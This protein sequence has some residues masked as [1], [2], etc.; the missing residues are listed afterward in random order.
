MDAKI[1]ETLQPEFLSKPAL[2]VLGDLWV[3][4]LKASLQ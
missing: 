2:M 3:K 1:K 4:D